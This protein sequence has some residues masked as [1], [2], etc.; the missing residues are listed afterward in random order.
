MQQIGRAE[1]EHHGAGR[2]ER[3]GLGRF[4]SVDHNSVENH[5]KDY[6]MKAKLLY[7]DS[8]ASCVL[9]RHDEAVFQSA[10]EPGGAHDANRGCGQRYQRPDNSECDPKMFRHSDPLIGCWIVIPSEARNLALILSS[11]A[12]SQIPRFARN[13]SF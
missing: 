6:G 13:D 12:Q 8:S 4:A 7:F 3:G 2:E 11:S 1:T 10:A 5:L 9:Q